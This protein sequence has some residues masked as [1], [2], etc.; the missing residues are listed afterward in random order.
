MTFNILDTT[1]KTTATDRVIVEQM[2]NLCQ[3]GRMTVL[4]KLDEVVDIMR[5]LETLLVNRDQR[6]AIDQ[7]SYE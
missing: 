2:E 4:S 6:D 5:P 3:G 7:F 1:R